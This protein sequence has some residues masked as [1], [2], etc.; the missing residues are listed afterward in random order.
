MNSPGQPRPRRVDLDALVVREYGSYLHNVI[1]GLPG[2]CGVCSTP[3]AGD[4]ARCWPC[5]QM[6][7]PGSVGGPAGFVD[8]V[9]FL[10]YAVEGGQAYS[11]LRG[12]KIPSIQQRYWTAAATWVVWL[13][14]RHGLCPLRG[15]GVAESQFLWAT[16]P[17]ARSGRLGEH[18]LHHIVRQVW[19]PHYREAGLA[20]AVGAG[21]QSRDYN[22][23]RFT[24]E[25]IASGSHVVLVDDSWTT[26]A[27]VQSAATALKQAGAAQVSALVLGR[28]LRD[29]WEPTRHFIAQGGL[30]SPFDP[31]VC[32]WRGVPMHAA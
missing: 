13:L 4:F 22:P 15:S 1:P 17:S 20:L 24:A 31:D 12:Y 10:T 32:P 18:P 6:L 9:A 5:S 26:G 8:R 7:P 14:G 28:L 23:R 19:G 2:L 30:R 25:P 27:N 3:V 29:A 21:G 11:V 16:V